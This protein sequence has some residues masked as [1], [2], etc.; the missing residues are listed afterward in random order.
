VEKRTFL[1]N[2]LAVA[3]AA[4]VSGVAGT[5]RAQEQIKL[6][7]SHFLSPMAPAQT[8]LSSL[9]RARRERLGGRIKCEIYPSM[10]LGGKPPQLYD[11]HA[12]ASPTSSGRFPATR[13]GLSDRGRVRAA[14]RRRRHRRAT[15]RAIWDFNKLHLREESRTSTRS[16][17]IAT[18]RA[19]AH[20][21]QAR[22]KMEDL[23]GRKLRLPPSRWATRS[24]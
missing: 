4:A 5:V 7:M 11:Q 12:R 15:A 21:G 3:G 9:G 16:C 8:K 14:L 6:R 23:Q 1:K 10:Q 24:S 20:E 17:C 19:R 2:T 22:H 13:R 18:A